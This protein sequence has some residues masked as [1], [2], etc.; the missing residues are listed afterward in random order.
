MLQELLKNKDLKDITVSRNV[1]PRYK[2][3]IIKN[4]LKKKIERIQDGELAIYIVKKGYICDVLKVE[5]VCGDNVTAQDVSVFDGVI[6]PEYWTRLN[7]SDQEK[8]KTWHEVKNLYKTEQR[9][10]QEPEYWQE[11]LK[12]A[13]FQGQK[14][15]FGFIEDV[16]NILRQV[17]FSDQYWDAYDICEQG[18][19][20]DVGAPAYLGCCI[21]AKGCKFSYYSDKKTMTV[22]KIAN[23]ELLLVVVMDP[24]QA[25][26]FCAICED[27]KKLS[28]QRYHAILE[29]K[30]I[31][32]RTKELQQQYE[33][34]EQE[35]QRQVA[36]NNSFLKNLGR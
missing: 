8:M 30:E 28:I 7:L 24:R 13:K 14:Q 2:D 32:K 4:F 16:L 25:E 18:H 21:E 34:I 5:V 15:K 22:R 11:K 17:R 1:K 27:L 23:E 9:K 12:N 19:E 26:D 29:R 3:I 35:N 36:I 31:E 20:G 33:K 6:N 10:R